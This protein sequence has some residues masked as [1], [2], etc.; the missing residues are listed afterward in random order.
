MHGLKVSYCLVF[1]NLNTGDYIYYLGKFVLNVYMV[2]IVCTHR[3][4]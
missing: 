2:V 1:N 3:S 4:I